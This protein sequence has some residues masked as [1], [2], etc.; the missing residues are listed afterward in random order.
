MSSLRSEIVTLRRDALKR[1]IDQY[2][3]AR[4]AVAL[5]L[6]PNNQLEFSLTLYRQSMFQALNDFERVIREDTTN[7]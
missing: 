4:T 2:A 5:T 1:A 3:H 6:E 7:A